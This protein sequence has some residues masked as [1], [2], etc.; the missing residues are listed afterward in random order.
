[1]LDTKISAQHHSMSLQFSFEHLWKSSQFCPETTKQPP[2]FQFLD[3]TMPEVSLS[4]QTTQTQPLSD[5]TPPC[6]Y[7]N[8]C[9]NKQLIKYLCCFLCPFFD[10][11][12][13]RNNR[14]GRGLYK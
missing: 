14:V 7:K 1:M 2:T 12:G 11:A 9:Q 10:C 4:L 3:V 5:L 8:P 6:I 13:D